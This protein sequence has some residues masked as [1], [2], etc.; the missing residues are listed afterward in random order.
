MKDF[1]KE[2][3]PPE[4]IN[5]IKEIVK[6]RTNGASYLSRYVLGI[7]GKAAF[8][9][10]S[11]DSNNLLQNMTII[12]KLLSETRPNMAP[13]RLA[14]LKL[15]HQIHSLYKQTT[16]F[17]EFKVLIQKKAS[18]LIMLSFESFNKTVNNTLQIFDKPKKILTCSASSTINEIFKKGSK[19]IE[20]VIICES[21]PLM[22]G[23]ETANYLLS[24][25]IHV[26]Y[27]TDCQAGLY[28][29]KCDIVLVGADSILKN[30]YLVNKSGTYLI[31][32]A[33]IR[34]NIPF[35]AVCQTDKFSPK[36]FEN[37]LNVERDTNN[38]LQLEEKEYSE[39]WDRSDKNLE[40]RNI[41]FDVTPLDL[42]TGIITEYG[43]I[44]PEDIAKYVELNNFYLK[45]DEQFS[46]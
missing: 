28:V 30:G 18:E 43:L 7:I 9:D 3:I 14:A 37:H 38:F 24:L 25:G 5:S 31:A 19:N 33:A 11:K 42:V 10:E 35:Y 8:L 29:G 21:R 39:V 6:D 32:L 23:R 16:N 15:L 17:I 34:E 20:E 40:I 45:C 41:Y 2:N 46:I 1:K 27:I 22:E 26:I 13:V 12:C 36:I 44:K 4:I